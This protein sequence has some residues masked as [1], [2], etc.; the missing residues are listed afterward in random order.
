LR[1]SSLPLQERLKA[2][3][4]NQRLRRQM[5]DYQ[6]PDVADY[7]LAKDKHKKLQRSIH[8]WERKFGV[9]EVDFLFFIS[10]KYNQS[11]GFNVR[12]WSHFWS[13]VFI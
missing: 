5:A 8:A 2:E 12:M 6:A 11:P 1:P 7:M 9:A 10:P 13:G 4:L 3:A